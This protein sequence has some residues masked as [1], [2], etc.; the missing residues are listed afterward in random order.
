VHY[1]P[2]DPFLGSVGKENI[3]SFFKTWKH[4]TCDQAH[5]GTVDDNGSLI[6]VSN[7]GKVPLATKPAGLGASVHTLFQRGTM[8]PRHRFPKQ[9]L[10]RFRC[11]YFGDQGLPSDG[12]PFH[13]YARIRKALKVE[14]FIPE[15][16]SM[17]H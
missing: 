15:D 7:Q 12:F 4:F 6:F 8:D 2:G 14:T 16:L 13:L 1:A 9:T 11:Q 17:L 10:F 5:V 3:R